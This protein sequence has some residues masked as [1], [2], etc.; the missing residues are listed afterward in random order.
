MNT[1]GKGYDGH[2]RTAG[3][4]YAIS[5]EILDSDSSAESFSGPIILLF[6]HSYVKQ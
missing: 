5:L 6:I 2:Y 3:Y 4:E 1:P